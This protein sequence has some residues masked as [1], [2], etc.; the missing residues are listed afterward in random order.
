[1]G[2]IVKWGGI[3]IAGVA[4]AILLLLLFIGWRPLALTVGSKTY[5]LEARTRQ[6]LKYGESIGRPLPG[7]LATFP[8]LIGWACSLRVGYTAWVFTAFDSDVIREPTSL[9]PGE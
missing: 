6:E 1:M 5:R 7:G 3:A 9:H 8:E 4:G 2:E